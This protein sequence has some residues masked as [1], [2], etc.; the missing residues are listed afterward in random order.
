MVIL[1]K[2][3]QWYLSST[4]TYSGNGL[5]GIVTGLLDCGRYKVDTVLVSGP[6]MRSGK[7]KN[8]SNVKRSQS[9][10]SLTLAIL[11]HTGGAAAV[12]HPFN[13][14]HKHSSLSITR[15]TSSA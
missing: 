11:G 2:L 3:L 7:I 14:D 9:F 15:S 8:E 12:D 13:I 5:P 6:L 10:L 4:H 1:G